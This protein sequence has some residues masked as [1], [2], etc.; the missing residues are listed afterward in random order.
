MPDALAI[1]PDGEGIEAGDPVRVLVLGADGPGLTWVRRV[2]GAPPVPVAIRGHPSRPTLPEMPETGPLVDRFGR[3]HRDLRLSVTDRCNLRCVH[4]L[5]EEGVTFQARDEHLDFDEIVRVAQVAHGLGI[6]SIRITGGEP[7]LRRGVVDLVARLA[8]IGFD[9]LSLT[10]N[11]T[12]LARL[13]PA[14]AQAGLDR[15]N[16]SC[17]SLRPER[18]AAIRR[19]GRLAPVLDAMDA[20]ERAGLGPIKVNVVLLAGVNDDEVLDF[21]AFARATG[22]VVRFIEFMPLDGDGAW[23]R[24]QVV[25][26]ADVVARIGARWPLEAVAAPGASAPAERFRFVDGGGEVGVI[27]SVDAPVLR[28]LRSTAPDRRRGAAQL[29]VRRSGALRTCAPARRRY[30]RGAGWAAPRGRMGEVSGPRDQR[31]VVHPTRPVDVDDRR[32][33]V[34]HGAVPRSSSR[35][36]GRF[37]DHG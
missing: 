11:G 18:Y 34:G 14:L 36:R 30:R 16:V 3:V 8:A 25:P 33:S 17:D 28:Y 37:G 24:S 23:Q 32:L 19:R 2:T 9:D 21:A 26:A 12:E 10:T 6:T 1:V 31:P 27:A 7:L 13:A 4:C 15:V 5:P 20:A 35:S 22:R 29:P